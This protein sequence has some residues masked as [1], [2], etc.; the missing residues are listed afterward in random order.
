VSRRII[1]IVAGLAITAI[2]PALAGEIA[3][4]PPSTPPRIDAPLMISLSNDLLGAKQVDDFRTG[5]T[6]ISGGFGDGWEFNVDHSILTLINSD[7]PG[8]TDEL[9]ASFG[10]RLIDSTTASSINRVSA[11]LGIRRYGEIY[12]E[13]LQ[14]GSHR[15]TGSTIEI[16][17]YTSLGRSDATAW[18]D[19]QRYSTRLIAPESGD[20]RLGY[21]LRGAA[22]WTS[23][24]QFDASTGAYGVA[25]RRTM[26]FWIGLRRD[27]RTGY[28]EPV[29]VETARQEQDLAA[30]FGLRWGPVVFETVQQFNNE[31]SY[32]ELRVIASG[33]SA[34]ETG[35]QSAPL[36]IGASVT[37]P[38]VTVRITGRYR[39]AWLNRIESAWQRSLTV[40]GGYGEPQQG[41]DPTVY[42][43]TMQVG[44]GIEWQRRLH[45]RDDWVSA[46]LAL[47]AGWQQEQIFGDADR[48]GEQ[49]SRVS[50]AVA[51]AAIGL[52]FD[53]GELVGGYDF[54]TRLGL[55]ASIPLS[56]SSVDMGGDSFDVQRP[57]LVLSVGMIFGRLSD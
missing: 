27:W 54:G 19:A 57:V 17:P 16:V 41:D 56:H 29:L 13:R 53:G 21:W 45:V 31:A 10:R 40:S 4:L 20:W 3:G 24:G 55:N 8:R 9:A 33:F 39:A 32:G 2:A 6:I 11:G 49:S 30:V 48:E 5:Q 18:V 1:P 34:A 14:N 42:R 46:W 26:D 51:L 23:G 37:A 43:R 22:L 15:I 7:A 36:T 50:G 35:R 47:G 12:G 52:Q 25:S 44:A 38:D 28:T